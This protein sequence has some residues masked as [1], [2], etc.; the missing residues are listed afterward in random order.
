MTASRR[1]DSLPLSK[2]RWGGTV[3]HRR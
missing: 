3:L 1:P 2:S